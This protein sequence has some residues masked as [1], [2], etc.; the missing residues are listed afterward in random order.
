VTGL[1]IDTDPDFQR[2]TWRIQRA[3]WVAFGLVLLAA[4]AG[5]FG[6]GPLGRVS[7]ETADASLRV[8]G[9]RFARSLTPMVLVVTAQP[10]AGQGAIAFSLDRAYADA[11]AIEPEFPAQVEITPDRVIYRFAAAGAGPVH[12]ALRV[13][14]Q[15]IGVV[16]GAIRREPDGMPL[17]L[18]H[19]VYP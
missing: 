7:A 18:T 16:S 17:R 3:A 10:T 15:R 11:V 14:P 9:D 6:N 8:D 12:V 2:R 4:L 13:T 19:F 1:Q 5:L